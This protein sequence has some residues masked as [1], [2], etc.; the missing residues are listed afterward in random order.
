MLPMSFPQED[1]LQSGRLK[2]PVTVAV[3]GRQVVD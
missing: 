2:V 1:M 3:L